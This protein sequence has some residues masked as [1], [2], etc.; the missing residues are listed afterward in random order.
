MKRSIVFHIL[1]FVSILGYS[2]G[3]ALKNIDKDGLVI[4]GYDPVAYFTEKKAIKGKSEWKSNYNGLSY[5]FSTK[6]NKLTFDAEPKKYEVQFGGFCAYAVSQGHVSPIDPN[7]C[8]V[9]KDKQNIER[10]ICQHNAKAQ[11]LWEEAPV[12]LL[13][14]ADSYWP[15]VVQN[16][17]KQIKIKGIAMPFVNVTGDGVAVS[18]YDVV[19]YFVNNKPTKGNN[20]IFEY[21]HGYKYLFAN[22]DNRL[23]FRENPSAYLPQYGGFCAYAMSLGKIRPVD[24][25]IW[26]IENGRL[27]LQHTQ[28]AFKLFKRDVNGNIIKADQ[29]WPT[30]MAK[31]AG[32]KVKYD[33]PAR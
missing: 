12:K 16:G 11:K 26:S 7:F 27:M 20:A 30:V 9:Q 32:K 3:N 8:Y 15:A 5:L 33:K 23:K 19:S 29:Y 13:V 17:G 28:D 14:D 2:Q 25:N 24:P 10:L 31:H 4:D 1:F 22:D 21:Y 6:E 18:G